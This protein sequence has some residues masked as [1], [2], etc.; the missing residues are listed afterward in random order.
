MRLSLLSL[1]FLLATAVPA[2]A[3]T[4]Q[5]PP[6]PSRTVTVTGSDTVQTAPDRVTVSFAV[7][8]RAEGPEAA[9]EENAEAARRALDAVRELG[10]PERQIQLQTLR[11]DQ[12]FE[13]R[14]RRRIPTGYVAR[15]H[16]E[17]VLDDLDALPALVARIV[18]EGANELGGIAYGLRDR[19]ATEDEALRRAAGR[20]RE[21]AE[22]LT[23]T[24]GAGLGRVRSVQEGA[25]V[26]PMP[27]PEMAF[28]RAEMAMDDA[29]APEPG[30]YAAG[31]IEVRAT[32]TV[33]FEIE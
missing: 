1:L 12:E 28:A 33:V 29:A 22:V 2:A 24:L 9:R 18:Q 6:F 16:L 7:V 31:E 10:V 25:V 23:Q 19:K 15:R 20:A 13:Y 11:L 17:V 3:Q 30:A 4:P 8:T 21:K 27:R 5:V 26:V 32:V 14:D